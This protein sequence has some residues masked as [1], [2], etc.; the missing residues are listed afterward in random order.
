M[1][2][3]KRE[4]PDIP[5]WFLILGHNTLV[6]RMQLFGY[7]LVKVYK[8]S[9]RD[10]EEIYRAIDPLW[11][12]GAIY[13]TTVIVRDEPFPFDAMAE[14]WISPEDREPKHVQVFL[15]ADTI[16]TRNA[17]GMVLSK[18]VGSA[19]KIWPL[20]QEWMIKHPDKEV[21]IERI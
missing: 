10:L 21:K 3:E 16:F 20:L 4:L 13:N 11:K 18:Y 7:S 1:A 8:C 14:E 17:R 6:D 15:D 12:A 19:D 5:I 9:M 2:L